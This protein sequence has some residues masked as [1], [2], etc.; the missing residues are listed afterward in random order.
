[1]N[2]PPSADTTMFRL[3]DRPDVQ[4]DNFEGRWLA[5]SRGA[6]LPHWILEDA[7]SHGA[8]SVY[9]KRLDQEARQ[10]PLLAWGEEIAAPFTAREHG[11]DYEI[12][13][14]AGY[15]QGIFLDQ[16]LNRLAVRQRA[17]PGMRVL[18][19]FAY[20]SGFS[21][22]AAM[23][24][25]IATSVDLSRPYLEWSKRNFQ[26]NGL[27]AA[28]HFF[29]RGDTL[30]WLRRWAKSNTTFDGIILDPP[31]FSR[32]EQGKVWRVEKDYALLVEL[33]ARVLN[34]GGWMLCCTN[35]RALSDR[36]FQDMVEAGLR[37]AGRGNSPTRLAPMPPEFQAEDYLKSLWVEP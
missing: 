34:P 5:Q 14:Q 17:A 16:R 10:P 11:L 32:N 24:G 28:A 36:A 30:D 3:F 20:T 21:V 23:N 15:S 35:F 27:D 37:A 26:L 12:D 1:V 2:P 31:T 9:W 29:T 25:A 18:N 19:T 33:A 22:A 7:A 4:V 8:R 13:F 6:V